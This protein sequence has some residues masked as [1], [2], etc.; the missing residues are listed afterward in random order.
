[1][2]MVVKIVQYSEYRRDNMLKFW[3]DIYFPKEYPIKSNLTIEDFSKIYPKIVNF[4]GL[5]KIIPVEFLDDKRREQEYFDFI[6]ICRKYNLKPYPE[7][8]NDIYVFNIETH[9][10]YIFK[11]MPNL[12]GNARRLT[13]EEMC[14]IF[15][16]PLEEY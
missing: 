4:Y 14:Y 8:S 10:R 11:W 9:E 2:K 15:Q 3:S 12:I 6:E 1:M 13:F 7:F 5:L 16:I